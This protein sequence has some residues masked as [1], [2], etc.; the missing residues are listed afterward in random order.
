MIY[1]F[2]QIHLSKESLRKIHLNC[3]SP[4]KPKLYFLYR[5]VSSALK[6]CRFHVPVLTKLH[7]LKC[8][9]YSTLVGNFWLHEDSCHILKLQESTY[10]VLQIKR[11]SA[12]FLSTCDKAQILP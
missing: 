2:H 6:N 3:C 10:Y 1:L 8:D 9:D 5:K 12:V 11:R 7:N 4:D